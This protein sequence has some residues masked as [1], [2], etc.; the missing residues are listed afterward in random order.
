M[1]DIVG[2]NCR[3][4]I[5]PVPS[6]Y[7]DPKMRKH[8]KDFC[9]AVRLGQKYQRPAEDREP[10]MPTNRPS[11]ELVSMQKNARKDGTLFN[12]LFYMKVF[13]LS[14]ELGEEKPYIVALQS[15][16]EGGKDALADITRLLDD[17]D[18]RM[19][20][21]KKEL[22]SHFFVQ[23]SISRSKTPQYGAMTPRRMEEGVAPKLLHEMFTVDEVQPWDDSRFKNV[24]KLCDATRNKGVVNLR[25]DVKRDQ[26]FAVKQMPNTWIRDNHADFISAHPSEIEMPWQDIGCTRYLNSVNYKYACTLD[27]VYRDSVNTFVMSSF[28]SGG[29]LFDLSQS[30]QTPGPSREAAFAPLVVELFS[31]LKQLHNMQIVHRDISL[32]NVLLTSSDV[33]ETDIRIIDFG[34]CSTM[35]TFRNVSGKASYQ[36][37]EMH[38]AS[39]HDAFLADMFAAGVLIYTLMVKDYPWLSTKTG[40][41]K[42]FEYVQKNG[43]RAYC[44]K[45]KVRGS[46]MRINECLSES[47]MYLI[48]GMLAMDPAKRLTL[49][50]KVW[51]EPWIRN[52]TTKC[53]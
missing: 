53:L 47:L 41:C 15:E 21:V 51:D 18:D 44:A 5:S 22:A 9:E 23:C 32:E 29:D 33:S 36:A 7:I 6:G 52:I 43:F 34:M 27:G 50:E 26:V 16:L 25:R 20:K 14:A 19:E 13:D 4:L 28:A 10:W 45:R 3:F 24:R 1:E 2:R 35:R 31:G 40:R 17:L 12:N 46:D 30:G 37:P 38:V 48:E 49:G 11:D 8:T 42:C 39:E